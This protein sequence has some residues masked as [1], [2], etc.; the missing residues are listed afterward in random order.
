[1]SV[2]H[3]NAVTANAHEDAEK[4]AISMIKGE[5]SDLGGARKKMDTSLSRLQSA[6]EYAILGNTEETQRM[7]ADLQQNQDFQTQ[8]MEEQSKMLTSIAE[9]QDAVRSDLKNIQKLL[10]MFEAQ[11]REDVTLKKPSAGSKDSPTSHRVRNFF[12]SMVDPLIEYNNIKD[13][14]VPDTCKWIFDEP[15]WRSWNPLEIEAENK[16]GVRVLTI[17]GPAGSGKSH[18]A[19]AAYDQLQKSAGKNSCIAGFFFREQRSWH[20]GRFCNAIY[21]MI[22]QIAEQNAELCEKINAELQREDVNQSEWEWKEFWEDFIVPLFP[23][24]ET[25]RLHIVWDGLDEVRYREKNELLQFLSNLGGASNANISLLCTT[26]PDEAID[27]KLKAAGAQYITTTKAK[28]EADLQA[29]IWTH[30]NNDDGLKRFSK[31]TKQTIVSKLTEKSDGK[32]HGSL[33]IGA[34]LMIDSDAL[35]RKHSSPIQPYWSR[36]AGA[37]RA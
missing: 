34:P 16:H 20:L 6:T 32:Y 28:Q 30:L 10:S 15:E 37:E 13:K 1:M 21:W 25:M 33:L 26:R 3:A 18:L 7:T 5:D 22:I 11:R 35:R 31:F 4:W 29:I 27:Q 9:G 2:R 19:V 14:I 36:T 24:T 12:S 17:Q 8:I 23:A